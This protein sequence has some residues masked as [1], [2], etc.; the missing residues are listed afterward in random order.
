MSRRAASLYGGNTKVLS[1]MVVPRCDIVRSSWVSVKQDFLYKAFRCASLFSLASFLF[2]PNIVGGQ[3]LP[4]HNYSTRDGLPSNRITALCQDS[5][6]FLWI[7]TDEGL[8]V[9]D[10]EAFKT[11][12][13]N[14]GLVNNFITSIIESKQSPGT[15]WIGSIAGGISRYKDGSFTPI[16]F[17][18]YIPKTFI[19][20]V[21]EDQQGT[22]WCMTTNGVF[23][24]SGDT[25]Q[26]FPIH[27]PEYINGNDMVLASDGKIWFGVNRRVYI[28]SPT[29]QKT[30]V[31]NL[32]LQPGAFINR[33][34]VDREGDIWIIG[35]DSTLR[36]FVG[37]RL[38]TL[39]HSSSQ[40]I[41]TDLILDR[42]GDLWITSTGGLCRI[43]KKDFPRGQIVINFGTQT[44][45]ES[46]LEQILEDREGDIWFGGFVTGLH[47]L[48]EKNVVTLQLSNEVV[49]FPDRKGHLWLMNSQGA[50]E[51]WK[52]NDGVWSTVNHRLLRDRKAV[53]IGSIRSDTR[54]RL[55]I[56]YSDSTLECDSIIT[57]ERGPSL[58]RK[59]Y[60]FKAGKDFPALIWMFYVDPQNYLWLSL[61]IGI[62]VI[63]LNASPPKV[64][65]LLRQEDELRMSSIRAIYRDSKSDVWFGSFSEGLVKLVGGDLTLRDLRHFTTN[66][67]LPDNGVRS[68]AEDD[69]GRLW[70]GT[71]FGGVAIYD[72]TKFRTISIKEGLLS[73]AVWAITKDEQHHM[74]LGTGGGAMSVNI[75]NLK[76][77]RWSEVMTKEPCGVYY[78]TMTKN[79]WIVNTKEA[80]GLGDKR[81]TGIAPPVHITN[82]TINDRLIDVRGGMEFPRHCSEWRRNQ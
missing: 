75:D 53:Q 62:E 5:K 71:R 26:H 74:W 2:L 28:Y 24:V 36:M 60:T 18:S 37:D 4:F 38:H 17:G 15:M 14:D 25:L 58:L 73:N 79:I 27:P 10:G 9:Y 68:L 48:S 51:C 1:H 35:K 66:E 41:V 8:S 7:G 22:I 70:I 64:I 49:G 33:M 30:N 13:T 16:K 69:Y 31:I 32:D 19:G 67:G 23:K 76:E 56:Q 63:D 39:W 57:R 44:T 80:I 43:P 6:G 3:V 77:L 46:Y 29:E 20:N 81:T 82:I 40:G 72:G 42:D 12:T 61:G 78:S 47:K 34:K 45:A 21:L 59:S 11:Y 65:T 54:G 52:N 50:W 55:W